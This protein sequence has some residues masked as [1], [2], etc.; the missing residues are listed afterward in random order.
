MISVV[1]KI[2]QKLKTHDFQ[3]SITAF[4]EKCRWFNCRLT[5]AFDITTTIHWSVWAFAMVLL[6]IN[7]IEAGVML[8]ALLS[9]IPHEYGHALAARY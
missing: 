5:T 2:L 6:L 8:L 3:K 7:P 1:E 9:I 4:F